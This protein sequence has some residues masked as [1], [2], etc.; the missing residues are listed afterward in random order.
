LPHRRSRHF[1]LMSL[2]RPIRSVH[3]SGVEPAA[4]IAKQGMPA[5]KASFHPLDRSADVCCWDAI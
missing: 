4:S 5:L 1:F 3:R 2:S